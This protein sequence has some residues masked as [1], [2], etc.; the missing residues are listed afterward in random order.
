MTVHVQR[1]SMVNGVYAVVSASSLL[2]AFA[3]LF[4][5]SVRIVLSGVSGGE[6]GAA[7]VQGQSTLTLLSFGLLFGHLV[8]ALAGARERLDA[9][10][11]RWVGLLH[12]LASALAVLSAGFFGLLG[13]IESFTRFV[14]VVLLWSMPFIASAVGSIGVWAARLGRRRLAAGW[15]VM[16]LASFP[17]VLFL[18]V[19]R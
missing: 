2:V 14:G 3:W 17:F 4:S 10:W 11:V 15:T 6:S 16:Y 9:R 18:G 8:F 19:L 5:G 12:I 1:T 13:G 7:L